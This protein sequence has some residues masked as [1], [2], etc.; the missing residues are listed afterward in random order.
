MDR[1][2]NIAGSHVTRIKATARRMATSDRPRNAR[3]VRGSRVLAACMILGSVVAVYT[4]HSGMSEQRSGFR[5]AGKHTL[6]AIASSSA[7]KSQAPNSLPDSPPESPPAPPTKLEQFKDDYANARTVV[8]RSKLTTARSLAE[9]RAIGYRGTELQFKYS[10]G[11]LTAVQFCEA[12][13]RFKDHDQR[14]RLSMLRAIA[15][16]ETTPGL[17]DGLLMLNTTGQ[18]R[19]DSRTSSAYSATALRAAKSLS[20]Q[21]RRASQPVEELESHVRRLCIVAI[22]HAVQLAVSGAKYF[23]SGAWKSLDRT[24]REL[25]RLRPSWRTWA[26]SEVLLASLGVAVTA[27]LRSILVRKAGYRGGIALLRIAARMDDP[28]INECVV[29]VFESP[30]RL[31]EKLN[32]LPSTWRVIFCG[33]VVP[34]LHAHL[35]A[36]Q[37]AR[38]IRALERLETDAI[39]PTERQRI[40]SM[41]RGLQKSN[42]KR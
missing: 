14:A 21:S 16:I 34:K 2:V 30:E 27:E 31:K 37:H 12:L 40:R 18:S 36:A 38:L 35:S 19:S 8:E 1:R 41:R 24:M 15:R 5:S 39:Y 3:T 6:P 10:R 29:Q 9:L 42:A 17:A 22:Q 28:A 11:G 25:D 23:G 13:T 20:R 26:Q 33:A 32:P 7:K 4:L